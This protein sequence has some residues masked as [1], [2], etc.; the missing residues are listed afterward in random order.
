MAKAIRKKDSKRK[1]FRDDHLPLS[2]ENF[3]IMGVGLV[4]ILA[5]YIAM[6]NQPVEGF[7]PLVVAPILLVLGYCIVIPLGLLYKKSSVKEPVAEKTP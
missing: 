6:Y 2:K 3:Q 5:G 1:P 4:L 7:L